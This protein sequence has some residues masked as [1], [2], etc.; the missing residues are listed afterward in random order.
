VCKYV[1]RFSRSDCETDQTRTSAPSF[2]TA[3][4]LPSEC[5]WAAIRRLNRLGRNHRHT[6]DSRAYCRCLS[7]A[8]TVI[9]SGLRRPSKAQVSD[10]Q[11]QR[12]QA[13]VCLHQLVWPVGL[14]EPDASRHGTRP[15]VRVA[16]GIDDGDARVYLSASFCDVPPGH[17]SGQTYVGKNEVRDLLA[18][19]FKSLLA[20]CCFHNLMALFSKRLDRHFADQRIIFDYEYSQGFRLCFESAQIFSGGLGS[21]NYS[22]LELSSPTIVPSSS[23][24]GTS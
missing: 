4:G 14:L 16:R 22:D 11:L 10:S 23:R 13:G 6:S 21:V 5:C 19:V 20:G 9:S 2:Q 24:S 7:C 12:R 17:L 8:A 18:A 15:H 1:V 3:L